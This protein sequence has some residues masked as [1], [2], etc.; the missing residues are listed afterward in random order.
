MSKNNQQLIVRKRGYTYLTS[1]I[2]M[3]CAPQFFLLFST[4]FSSDFQVSKLNLKSPLTHPKGWIFIGLEDV[5]NWV[6]DR[7][8]NAQDSTKQWTPPKTMNSPRFTQDLKE[9]QAYFL[10]THKGGGEL[11]SKW[12][13]R[14]SYRHTN[15]VHIWTPLAHG[16][17]VIW[18]SIKWLF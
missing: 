8:L 16:L 14:G 10:L 11:S 7:V 18:D 15:Q 13:G 1:P 12:F 9:A 2:L 5:L 6:G 4:P 17:E 3:S